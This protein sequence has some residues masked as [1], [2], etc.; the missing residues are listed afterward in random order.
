MTSWLSLAA[1]SLLL[2]AA[3]AAGTA[4]LRVLGARP[5][6]GE[7]PLFALLIG[8]GLQGTLLLGMSAMGWMHPGMLWGATLLPAAFGLGALRQLRAFAE[9]AQR[10]LLNLTAFERAALLVVGSFVLVILYVGAQAPVTDWDSQMY[11]LRI[12]KQLLAEGRLYL[13]ADGNHLAF[14]GLF[15][16]LYLPL[17]AIGA[18]A[19]PALLNAAMTLALGATLAVAGHSLLGAR[20]GLLATIA[21]W[22]SSSLLLVGATPRVDIAL[23]AALA[24][25]HFAV[26]RAFD[27]DAPWA[28]PVAALAA[29]ITLSMKYH[30]LPYLGA[31]APFAL[32]AAWTRERSLLALGRV[33]AVGL[34]L[35]LLAWTP[36]LVKNLV[37]FGAPLFPFLAEQRLVPFLADL[38]GSYAIPADIPRDAL[39]AMGRAREPISL[40]AL[41]FR[42][43]ALSIEREAQSYTRNPLFA[44]LPLALLYLRDRRM[45]ALAL[46]GIAYLV[47]TLG[48]FKH[49]NLRYIIP[50]LPMLALCAVEATRRFSERFRDPRRTRLVLT[51]LALLAVTPAL[52][53]SWSRLVS[54]P[55]A[56]VAL[57]LWQRESL[58]MS[59]VPYAVA[60]LVETA[61]PENARILMLFEARGLYF[62]REVL[63]DNLL[64]NLAILQGIGATDR[65]LAGSGITHLLVNEQAPQYYAR[66][67]ANL[68]AL[69]WDRFPD[70]AARCLVPVGVVRG[71]VLFRLR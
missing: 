48:W 46:P 35:V 68:H 18:D 20:T 52:L 38:S 10:A 65:C 47:F 56:Q 8:L 9:A 11:H 5:R 58:L 26:L 42:P 63:Q 7:Q 49:T 1:T 71:E 60:Q 50:A 57:G 66:R 61:T 62:N 39:G 30:A 53:V 2:L 27:D 4:V 15:Q 17:M 36:W 29:G 31:L 37:F 44:L 19:G 3:L 34:A 14:L 41:L 51:S 25:T 40:E 33:A 70:F 67:G 54:I 45:L 13:P 22:G 16:F 28:L 64:T 59:E 12:P 21:V 55:R 6:S 43:A 69:G 32:W 24:I 23:T